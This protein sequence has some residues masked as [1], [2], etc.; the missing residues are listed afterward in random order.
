M[1]LFWGAGG[2]V[3]DDVGWG[4][5]EWRSV[6]CVCVCVCVEGGGGVVFCICL[7][8]FVVVVL[9]FHCRPEYR[10]L[11]KDSLSLPR[12][13]HSICGVVNVRSDIFQSTFAIHQ[14][15]LQSDRYFVCVN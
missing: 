14:Q 2:G 3:G 15:L 10:V 5:W 12:L 7:C 13:P 4:G 1:S 6:V 9:S 8:C 11:K